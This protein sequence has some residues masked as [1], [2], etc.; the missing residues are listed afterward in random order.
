MADSEFWRG[1][2]VQFQGIPDF[3]G[4]LRADWQ[5]KV[6]SGGIGDWRFAGTPSDFVQTAFETSARRGSFEI[7]N[8]DCNGL[9]AAWFDTL[10][11]EG[12]NF[13]LSDRYLTDR[14]E[15]GTKGARYLIGSIYRLCEA[16]V[17]LCQKLEARALQSEFEAKHR[18]NPNNWSPLRRQWEAYRQIKNLITGPHER[19][20]EALVRR[21]LA[22]Q[23]GIKPEKVTLK[24]IQFEVSGLLEAYPAITVVPSDEKYQEPGIVQIGSAGQSD[25]KTFVIPLLEAKGWSILDW[26]NEAGV[27]HATAHDYLAQQA[28]ETSRPLHR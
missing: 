22:E 26:A 11:K 5:Y 4:E 23:Y 19:I 15:D 10:R 12:I 7:A 21:T 16:S 18:K 27:A 28:T 6:N 20:P 24:Q 1:L 9:L 14:N 25:R 2:A 3:T 8:A 17:K 13:Q